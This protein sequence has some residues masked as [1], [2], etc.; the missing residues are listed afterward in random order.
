MNSLDDCDN[1]DAFLLGD[2][3]GSEAAAFRTH[4]S[5]CTACR[6]SLD[7]QHWIDDLLRSPTIKELGSPS[8][9]LAES[10]RTSLVRRRRQRR[11]VACGFAAAAAVL[12]AVGWT[13]LTDRA[14]RD[15]SSNASRIDDA[16]AETDVAPRP[17]VFIGDEDVIVVP[18]ASRYPNVTVVRV[19]PAY[20]PDAVVHPEVNDPS[21]TDR[22]FWPENI[23]G[24]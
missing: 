15:T 3:A 19:Y 13:S 6:E 8:A 18:V 9:A 12:V 20:Q 17:A 14:S 24:D 21:A 1:L 22:T 2:L 5:S 7:E 10:I 23:N 11:R 4:L 16:L